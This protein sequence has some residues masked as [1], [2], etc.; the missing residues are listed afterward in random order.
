VQF[1]F[2][3]NWKK[4]SER[5][6]TPAKVGQARE[7]FHCLLKDCPLADRSFLDI[8]FGQGLSLLLAAE[9]GARVTGLDI[10]PTCAE[11]LERNKQ[12]LG[13]DVPTE[14]LVGSIL[15][16]AAKTR[17]DN[18]YFD[19]VHSWGVLHH[20]GDMYAAIE[21][22]VSLVNPGGCL[23]LAIYNRH[24]SSLIWKWIKWFYCSS[25]VMVRKILV[26]L[27]CPIIYGAKLLVTRKNPLKMTRG[28]DF[29]YNVIDWVGGYPYEYASCEEIVAFLADRGFDLV[30]F[31]PAQVPTGCN[32]FVFRKTEH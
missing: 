10:N 28:M 19:V 29:Y 32:E 30:S 31:N 5:R 25:P 15:D 17:L 7:Q 23:V 3:Q 16:D 1:D 20:T 4:F 11:V 27:F 6:L 9:A 21:Q 14:I 22:A 26:A 12:V 18:R 24:W 2:G 13:I 8:G